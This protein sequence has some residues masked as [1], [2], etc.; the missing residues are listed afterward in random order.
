MGC[1]NA[2]GARA[3]SGVAT[4]WVRFRGLAEQHA[5]CRGCFAACRAIGIDAS[6]VGPV[7]VAAEWAA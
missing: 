5:M 4:L 3:C 1:P 7:V 2:I 6:V